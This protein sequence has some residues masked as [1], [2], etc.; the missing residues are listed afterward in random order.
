MF[1]KLYKKRNRDYSSSFEPLKKEGA[2]N[3]PSPKVIDEGEEDEEA[4]QRV[5]DINNADDI[6]WELE[7]R[8]GGGL[9]NDI[10]I[11]NDALVVYKGDIV[12]VSQLPSLLCEECERRDSVLKCETCDQIFCPKCYNL[13]HMRPKFGTAIHPHE[14][15]KDLFVRPINEEDTSSVVVDNKF[16]LPDYECHEE[17]LKTTHDITQPN[18]L[19][20]TQHYKSIEKI[21]ENRAVTG[22]LYKGGDIL[23]YIDPVTKNEVYGRVESEWDF[24][25]DKSAP[26]L[27]RGEGGGLTWYVVRYLG[28][29]SPAVLEL[30]EADRPPDYD[31]ETNKENQKHEALMLQ[32]PN[33]EGVGSTQLRLERLMANRINKRV[34]KVK[35][36]RKYGPKHHLNPSVPKGFEKISEDDD[37]SVG[38][39]DEHS[40][41]CCGSIGGDRPATSS[42]DVGM[43]ISRSEE[44]K[45]VSTKKLT[46]A[47]IRQ[48][49]LPQD[50]AS[51]RTLDGVVAAYSYINEIEAE[52]NHEVFD[53]NEIE[54]EINRRL[55]ILLLPESSLTK[56]SDRLKLLQLRKKE[57]IR[58][59]LVKRFAL[60]FDGWTSWAFSGWKDH[61]D[62]LR[63][64][65]QYRCATLVQ[66]HVRR[67][68]ARVSALLLLLCLAY[69]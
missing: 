35:K 64:Q 11:I 37:T 30:L 42:S 58:R 20:T 55:K 24:R 60:M 12:D 4:Q 43:H 5:I 13:C 6:A 31:E 56:P 45:I 52:L 33:L 39:F 50:N 54:P 15:D 34:E 65:E 66:K 49:N 16:Y 44:P 61:T 7:R 67:F 3:E 14:T 9:P 36:I 41:L 19:A 21:P 68:Q 46:A 22:L 63:Y 48:A 53:E 23:V 17:Y 2:K 51:R 57:K 29:A 32:L 28:E 62:Q 18:T 59:A 27:I 38:A 10:E 47:E 69:M 26:T 40:S 25:H 1:F 8:A